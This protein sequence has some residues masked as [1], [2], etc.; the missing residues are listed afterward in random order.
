MNE[1]RSIIARLTQEQQD[2]LERID[3][4][5]DKKDQLAGMKEYQSELSARYDIVKKTD[6][7]LTSA[8]DNFVAA[9]MAPLKTSFE[10]YYE[11]LTGDKGDF[12]IDASLSIS[13]REEGAYHDVE[14]Q[15][16]GIGDM[17]GLAA[18]MALLDSMYEGEKPF[19]IMDD[20]FVNLDDTNLV[21]AKKFLD[22]ISKEYQVI[23][24][25][26]HSH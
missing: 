20:S 11:T 26:C 7:Y 6:K 24:L 25:T 17:I 23:Y 1:S 14:T 8:K 12:E 21:G 5:N 16:D 2:I 3:D 13:L 18:R 15:S 10:K 19:I 22:E 4:L 9:Y